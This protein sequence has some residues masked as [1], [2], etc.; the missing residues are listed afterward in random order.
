MA[1]S[2]GLGHH[3]GGR[4][5]TETGS[6]RFRQGNP[7][8]TVHS[9]DCKAVAVIKAALSLSAEHDQHCTPGQVCA[10]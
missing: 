1:G 6:L 9:R 4:Q 7:A 5:G 3:R 2:L 8:R 10:V